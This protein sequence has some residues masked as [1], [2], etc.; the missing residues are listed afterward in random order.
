MA[1][2]QNT[3][4]IRLGDW[5]KAFGDTLINYDQEVQDAIEEL[6]GTMGIQGAKDMAQASELAYPGSD[7]AK[8]WRVKQ[9]KVRYHPRVII[10]SK[11]HWLPHLLESGHATRNGGRVSGRLHIAPVE[12]KI[13]EDFERK[14]IEIIERGF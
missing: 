11:K 2:K 13:V 12:E 14:C 4:K 3:D 6:T 9:V 7:Y 1:I 5:T 10:Y 8:Q